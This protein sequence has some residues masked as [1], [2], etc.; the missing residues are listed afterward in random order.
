MKTSTQNYLKAI[1]QLSEL[2]DKSIVKVV[3][4]S[5]KLNVSMASVS[6]MVKRLEQDGYVKNTPYKG[7]VLTKK[8][9]HIGCN[10]VRHHRIWETYLFR[11]LEFTWDEVHDE[12]ELLEHAS[13]NKVIEKLEILM[14]YPKFDPH[15]NPIPDKNGVI[16]T[17]SNETLLSSCQKG[18][19]C[20]IVRFVDLDNTYLHFLNK[21][22]V[23]VHSSLRIDD[24]LEFD[25]TVVCCINNHAL[26]FSNHAANHI[27]VV[28]S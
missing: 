19:C 1:Y 23:S 26:H 18:D 8:G 13:S 16:P 20:S 9:S 7:L 27:Y 21:H 22:N 12:A 5:K 25:G 14:G 15:G 2:E 11:V 10:M 28:V 24:I 3:D 17:I 4:L 6:E